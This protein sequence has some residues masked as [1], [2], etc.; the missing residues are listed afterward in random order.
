MPDPRTRARRY[1]A[2]AEECLKRAALPDIE[3][4]ARQR[5]RQMAERY[6]A[7]AESEEILAA[8]HDRLVSALQR[9]E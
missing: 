9:G 1:R 6:I 8:Q 5:Q 2:R 4:D 3:A 7:L